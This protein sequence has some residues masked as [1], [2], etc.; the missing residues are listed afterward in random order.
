MVCAQNGLAR[1]GITFR[2]EYYT[3]QQVNQQGAFIIKNSRLLVYT[4]LTKDDSKKKEEHAP[5]M[6]NLICEFWHIA[7]EGGFCS[8]NHQ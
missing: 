6:D 7:T 3:L 5:V 4:S 2:L 1:K 8:C